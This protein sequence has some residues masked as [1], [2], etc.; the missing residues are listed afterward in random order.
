M[1]AVE[2]PEGVLEPAGQRITRL[3]LRSGVPILVDEVYEDFCKR[4]QVFMNEHHERGEQFHYTTFYNW[5]AEVNKL[6]MEH[7]KVEPACFTLDGCMEV[8]Q[9][10]PEY[11]QVEPIE[12]RRPNITVPNFQPH[13]PGKRR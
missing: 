8:T 4:F 13:G 6:H 5:R 1:S 11:L 9:I 12:V 3:L 7:V 2:F 10:T